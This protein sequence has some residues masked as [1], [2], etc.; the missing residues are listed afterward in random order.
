MVFKRAL[1]SSFTK[2]RARK[3][4]RFRLPSSCKTSLPKAA[5][6]SCNTGEPLVTTFRA[7]TSAS[8]TETTRAANQSLHKDLPLAIPPVKPII[9][10][11]RESPVNCAI[12]PPYIN[13][14][15]PAIAKYGPKAI[16]TPR[17]IRLIMAKINPVTAEKNRIN[18]N[19]TI[20]CQAQSKA[21]NLKSPYPIP[22]FPIIRR[23]NQ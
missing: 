21:S 17:P 2:A 22:S 23:N 14:N 16:G 15:Q 10:V 6:S 18:G 7:I 3:V 12:S 1:A 20:P 19:M 8:I 11:Y 5:V 4:A 13:V 9:M